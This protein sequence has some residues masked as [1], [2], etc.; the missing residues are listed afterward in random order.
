[1]T[2]LQGREGGGSSDNKNSKCLFVLKD[3]ARLSVGLFVVLFKFM[4]Q[5]PMN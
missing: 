2:G 1:M 3:G 4:H 5:L